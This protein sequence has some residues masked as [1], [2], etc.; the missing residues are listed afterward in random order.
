MHG[1]AKAWEGGVSHPCSI[2]GTA[3]A[4]PCPVLSFWFPRACCL[5]SSKQKALCLYIQGCCN[6]V[7]N[8]VIPWWCRSNRGANVLA[9]LGLALAHVNTE[10]CWQLCH[11]HLYALVPETQLCSSAA[12]ALA[13]TPGILLLLVGLECLWE[14]K[15]SW[16]PGGCWRSTSGLCL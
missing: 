8:I 16:M 11:Q 13:S 7:L 10:D 4:F 2:P 9:T 15:P 5:A 3:A 14:N 6:T 12:H 1:I